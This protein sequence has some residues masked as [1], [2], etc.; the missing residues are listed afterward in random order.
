MRLAQVTSLRRLGC[1]RVHTIPVNTKVIA[2]GQERT[3]AALFWEF[4]RVTNFLPI[5]CSHL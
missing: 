3:V 1:V 2:G 5:G 4:R